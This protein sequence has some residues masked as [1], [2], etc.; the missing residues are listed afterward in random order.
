MPQQD[1]R[2]YLSLAESAF[3]PVGVTHVLRSGSQVWL[4]V[5]IGG[6]G[7]TPSND[8]TGVPLEALPVTVAQL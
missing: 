2:P 8:S 5:S 1:R 6:D 3:E 7:E 4:S